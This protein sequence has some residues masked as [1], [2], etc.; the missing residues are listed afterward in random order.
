MLVVAVV[1]AEREFAKIRPLFAEIACPLFRML[2]SAIS[3]LFLSY[4]RLPTRPGGRD[5]V[6]NVFFF[7]KCRV[8]GPDLC[9]VVV[10]GEGGG[11][12]PGTLPH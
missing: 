9:R 8:G 7:K 4:Y 1:V 10:P 5:M 12:R 11:V 2:W 3:A 6:P